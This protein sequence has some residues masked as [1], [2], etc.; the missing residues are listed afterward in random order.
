MP[1]HPREVMK[2]AYKLV[3]GNPEYDPE[4]KIPE[5]VSAGDKARI[6]DTAN[7]IRLI[8]PIPPLEE[9]LASIPNGGSRR[10]RKS[11]SKKRR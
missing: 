11:R 5:E 6:T 2:K 10:R 1:L 3:E 8:R 4:Y 7:I 9:M